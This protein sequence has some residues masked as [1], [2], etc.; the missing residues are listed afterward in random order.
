[1]KKLI[2][3]DFDGVILKSSVAAS[4]Y[5]TWFKVMG[6]LLEDEDVR[7]TELKDDFFPDAAFWH[8]D[9]TLKIDIPGA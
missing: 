7:Q 5:K 6:D 3:F 1:M 2:A 8:M 9:R 4:A